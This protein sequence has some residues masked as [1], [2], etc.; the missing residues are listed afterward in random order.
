MGWSHRAGRG[1]DGRAGNKGSRASDEAEQEARTTG[2]ENG[3]YRGSN[4]ALPSRWWCITE[5]AMVMKVAEQPSR[6]QWWGAEQASMADH[7]ANS[8]DGEPTEQVNWGENRAGWWWCSTGQVREVE[9]EQVGGGW[10]PSESVVVTAG[11][12]SGGAEPSEAESRAS[13][14]EKESPSLGSNCACENEG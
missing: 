1:G 10:L 6:Q 9:A 7:R 5:Q 13:Q 14:W 4:G 11:Q 2:L 12:P 3:G 8:G